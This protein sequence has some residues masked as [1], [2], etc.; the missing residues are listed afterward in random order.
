MS[1]QLREV[2][3][4]IVSPGIAATALLS[5]IFAWNEFFIGLNLTSA[6]TATVPIWVTGT[7]DGRGQF[8][9][10]LSAAATLASIPVIAAGWIAQKRLVRGLALGAIK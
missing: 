4:P 8:F 5:F 2:I 7:V 3:L 1:S 6:S 10:K 9:A